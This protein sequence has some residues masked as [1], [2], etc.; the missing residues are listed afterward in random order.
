[1]VGRDVQYRTARCSA[2][3]ESRGVML[4]TK[5]VAMGPLA[6]ALIVSA[7]AT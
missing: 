4:Q 3:L 5:A 1:M 6:A 2:G 7:A